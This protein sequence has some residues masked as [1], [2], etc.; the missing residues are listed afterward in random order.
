MTEN[1]IIIDLATSIG[2]KVQSSEHLIQIKAF[3]DI[4]K[5]IKDEVSHAKKTRGANC[6]RDSDDD[7]QRMVFFIDGTRGAGKSTFLRSVTK[8]LTKDNNLQTL[9]ELDPTKV[10]TGEHIFVSLLFALKKLIEEKQNKGYSSS[11]E[12]KYEIWRKQ[13]KKLA[14]GLQLL[15]ENKNQLQDIDAEAFLDWGLERVKSGIEFADEFKEL[16]KE[17]CKFLDK[18]A[19]VI[20]IDDADTNFAKGKQI[21]E[22]IRRYL[23]SP[24][25]VTLI[26]GDLQL[27][28]HLVR[29]FYYGSL[30]ENIYK[31]DSH[32]NDEQTKLMDHLENQYL[33]KLFPLHQRTHLTS[34][35][36][37]KNKNDHY[38]VKFKFVKKNWLSPK[39]FD[40][41]KIYS[42]SEETDIFTKIEELPKD[43][44]YIKLDD[45][46]NRLLEEGMYIKGER[47]LSLYKEFLLK[48]PLRSIIQLLQRSTQNMD[49]GSFT[50]ECVAEGIRAAFRGNLHSHQVDVNALGARDMNALNDAV[51]RVVLEDGE[52]DT[53]CYLRP[54][55]SKES[56]RNSFVALAAEVARHCKG[57]PDYAIDY[58]LQ[59]LG[60][61]ALYDLVSGESWNKLGENQKEQQFRSY[62]SI[63]RN[64]NSLNWARH[65]SG[66]LAGN[67]LANK[68]VGVIPL[69]KSKLDISQ[70]PVFALSRVN[71]TD[72]NKTQTY[73]SIFNILGIVVRFLSLFEETKKIDGDD[74][75]KLKTAVTNE[76]KQHLSV[77]TVSEP[78]WKEGKNE[79]G[80][81]LLSSSIQQNSGE[82]EENK[83]LLLATK[84][85]TWLK[86]SDADNIKTEIKPSA[87]FLGKVWTR[88]YFSLLN[89]STSIENQGAARIMEVYALCLINAL[90]VEESY[91]HYVN[92]TAP[93]VGRTNPTYHD[94]DEF[95]KKFKTVDVKQFPLTYIIVTCPLILGL[96]QEKYIET[97]VQE[98]EISCE[99]G[100]FVSEIGCGISLFETLNAEVIFVKKP[101]SFKVKRT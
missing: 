4:I 41:L 73:A 94:T 75:E 1:N 50:P 98:I 54:Q 10:E 22:M 45:I 26:T 44:I 96:I 72:G 28:S 24:Y 38:W 71:I 76:L 17:S 43:W 32:R 69:M 16:I 100:V 97:L 95:I 99:K 14:G 48:Q 68:G 8:E 64:D 51:F 86:F 33:T 29:D 87:V 83:L 2:D 40:K 13:F 5:Q 58:M 36:D 11:K 27:Y 60:S 89:A 61:I 92:K 12:D 49:D 93:S 57:R 53:G 23:D 9:I 91:Y 46:I 15:N 84:I 52:F 67:H 80:V 66:I 101:S 37:L 25:L 34:L 35:W 19:L 59:G 42:K 47:D 3:N 62:F 39:S 88:L 81:P 79:K 90:F 20:S 6:C 85:T 30:G 7:S 65:A 63:G 82:P 21:L 31:R 18:D 78:P 56:L 70:M 77:L 55:P 74:S